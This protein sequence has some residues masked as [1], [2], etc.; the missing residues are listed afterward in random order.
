MRNNSSINKGVKTPR[1]LAIFNDHSYEIC[2]RTDHMFAVLMVLQWVGGVVAAYW[3]SPKAWIGT[4]S[5]THLHVWVAVFLGAAISSLP[6]FL[7]LTRPGRT[8]TRYTIAIGQ[9]LMGGLLIHLTG[10]R[11]ETHFHVFGSLAFLSFYRDWRVLIPA[12]IVVAADHILR[13]VLWPQ[14]V[15]GVLTASNWRWVEHAG[16]VLFEDIF[17]LIA[18]KRS[19][20][21]MWDIATRTAASE[22][23]NHDLENRVSQRTGQLA[24]ANNE[25]QKEVAERRRAAES[26]K[27]SQDWLTAIFDSSRDGIIVEENE[28]IIYVNHSYAHLFGYEQDELLGQPVSLVSEQEP[29]DWMVE[30]SRRRIRNEEAPSL[31]EFR[32]TRKD[33]SILD[34]EASVST[35]KIGE[36]IYIIALCRDITERKIGEEALRE[37]EAR[38]GA[39]L[40]TALDCIISIDHAGTILEFNPAAEK[41]FGHKR[42][43]VLGKELAEVI[44]PPAYRERH[45]RGLAHYLTTGEGGML[46]RRIEIS[47][48]R[49]DGTEFPV[50]L[51]V[52]CIR[53]KE[54]LIFTAYLRD[55]TERK[56]AEDELAKQ[57]SFL[58]QVIDL[59]PNFIFAND[60]QG[61][62]TLVNQAV[63]EAYGKTVDEIL[64]KTDGDFNS[65][66][67]EVEH[68]RRDDLE[69]I[70]TLQEKF[71][72]EEVITDARGQLRWLQ[73]I[74]RPIV[75]PNGKADQILGIATDITARKQAEEALLQSEEQLR[76]AQKI[77]AVGKLAG[78]VA[79]DFNNLL[80]VINGYSDICLR[81]LAEDDPLYR[82]IEEINKAGDKAAG[83]TRQLLAFS[84]KQIM[85]A[86][87]FDLN[88][89]VVEIN[90]M[91]Q[92]LIGEDID[93]RMG[94]SANLDKVKADPSQIEQVLLNLVVN[95]R[96]AMPLGGK[97]T[98]ETTNVSLDKEYSRSHLPVPP[99]KY[100]MLAVSDTGHGM[101]AATQAR[102]FEP[103]F[104][105]KEVG[106]GTGLGLSTVYGIVKQSGGFIWVYSEVG[107]GTAFKIYLP[108][109][110]E[111]AEKGKETTGKPELIK[112]SETILLVEDEELVRTLTA[113]I[114]RDA[115][116]HL[117]E[118]KDG[119]DALR[120]ASEHRGEIQLMLTDVVMP[121]MS[122]RELAEQ[123]ATIRKDMEVL[124]MSGYT[125]D[126][127]VLHGVL[128][129]GTP[130]IGKP[131]SPTA[132]T[133]KIREV[134][135][136]TVVV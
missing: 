11:I 105:T 109:V 82:N 108:S 54:Q 79:H 60:R 133:S 29:T 24:T 98:I 6:I 39:I 18:I 104:T 87:V 16:W 68:F 23:L 119:I 91:L 113:E 80:T 125:D 52:S 69:V 51:A 25:L 50:D 93:L 7:A 77:E 94:L 132:L 30:Y 76:Q 111:T 55:I 2:K 101:D 47:A 61:R 28:R 64:G 114:L 17:L 14:S 84:R 22:N 37:S 124:Y 90:N 71:I 66:Q 67:E 9:M 100:V 117:L 45:R 130:F 59:I 73:T 58:R 3:I 10:G 121:Q 115:G 19:V 136:A 63:A 34:L 49:A 96:D 120:V 89:V 72:P 1:T 5:H 20:G 112:G 62:F 116:Y 110:L 15:Y 26:L 46:G 107:Q 12:T 57:R 53:L 33:G 123:F 75:S 27:E 95:A 78:G 8:S 81:R 122:G 131:F 41:T 38:K 99:G 102:I 44:I 83:L 42:A 36:K 48:M 92:R 43:D 4:T 127:I 13:G 40:E 135:D 103:F 31:Y 106:K 128:D 70:N 74:K 65:N 134:I 126:A 56:R 21:E 86:K 118:A 85:Q 35:A 88:S 97:L 32:G 129:E